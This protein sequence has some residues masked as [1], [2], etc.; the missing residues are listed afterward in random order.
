[1]ILR[2]DGRMI[3]R[4][5][6][7]V[8]WRVLLAVLLLLATACTGDTDPQAEE[9]PTAPDVGPPGIPQDPHDPCV[10]SEDEVE[11]IAG[12]R[13]PTAGVSGGLILALCTYGGEETGATSPAT[14]D[15][16]V[17]DLE[18]VSAESGE[19]VDGEDYIAELTEGVGTGGSTSLDGFGDGSAVV[20]SYPFGSQAW[21]WVGDLVYGGYA[22][23]LEDP[24]RVATEVLRAVLDQVADE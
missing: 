6:H 9:S 5:G 17:V 1:M 13:L 16:A 15:I 18:R 4:A 21:A 14:V 8:R 3:L 2:A 20:L 12:E 19:E 11:E 23:D 24:D 10:L 22:S 7:A